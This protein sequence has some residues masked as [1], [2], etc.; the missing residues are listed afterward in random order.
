MDF[1]FLRLF[2]LCTFE[3]FEAHNKK[4]FKNKY[5]TR[6]QRKIFS[7]FSIFVSYSLVCYY[8]SNKSCPMFIVYSLHKNG[9]DFLD[10]LYLKKVAKKLY[11][12]LCFNNRVQLLVPAYKSKHFMFCDKIS[13]NLFPPRTSLNT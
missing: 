12:I 11:H 2:L 13:R 9:H 8:M 7:P 10:I 3:K 1:N 4:K 6:E 5:S